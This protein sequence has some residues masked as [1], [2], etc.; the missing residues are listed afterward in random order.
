MAD[1]VGETAQTRGSH[2]GRAGNDT[3][4]GADATPRPFPCGVPYFAGS[5]LT[6]P[7]S[8]VT[9]TSMPACLSC[10]VI[11]LVMSA[12][13]IDSEFGIS[14]FA[15]LPFEVTSTTSVVGPPLAL[16]LWILT[17]KPSPST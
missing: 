5:I 6:L 14:A 1:L 13:L 7:F 15:V 12:S 11:A 16:F 17:A 10:V 9:R 4:R 3:G 8:T 2:A